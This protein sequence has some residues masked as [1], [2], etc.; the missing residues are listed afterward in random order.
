MSTLQRQ[1]ASGSAAGTNHQ[2]QLEL[3]LGRSA[4]ATG[5]RLSGVVVLRC[6]SRVNVSSVSV[7]VSGSETPASASLA[8][9]LRRRVS[10]F[11]REVILSGK[12]IPRR[13]SQRVSALWN[14][15]LRRDTGRNL[16]AGEHLYP[17]Y[18]TLPASLP[19]S[20]QGRAGKIDYRVT[21]RVRIPAGRGISVCTEVPVVFVPREL[22]ARPIAVSYPSSSGAVQPSEMRVSLEFEG[23]TVEAGQ[24]VRGR[25]S[26]AN[27]Q[28]T[29][30]REVSAALVVCEWVKSTADEELQRET[31]GLHVFTPG[32]PRAKSIDST[33]ELQAPSD[34]PPTVEGTAIS[35]IWLLRLSV[36]TSPPLELKAPITVFSPLSGT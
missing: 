18:I 2:P 29:E 36:D 32:D 21:A 8:R 30:I 25:F 16:S 27:P 7:S 4:F 15:F 22:R 35:V 23:R 9:A 3:R 33:F 5:R 14:A 24:A 11:Y 12:E 31:K 13:T 26:I 17:F 20:Y 34:A 10:F 19:P 6:A 1:P 28:Q